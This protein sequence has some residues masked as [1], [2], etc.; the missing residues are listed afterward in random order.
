[1]EDLAYIYLA[2]NDEIERN[3][4]LEEE[5]LLNSYSIWAPR[6]PADPT[7][8]LTIAPSEMAVDCDRDHVPTN[9]A[10]DTDSTFHP[11]QGF[12]YL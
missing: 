9:Q 2:L 12:F 1:M 3:Q 4:D 5:R 6:I 10:D 8:D 7:Q 11:Y